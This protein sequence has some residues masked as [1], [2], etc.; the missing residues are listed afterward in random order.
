MAGSLELDTLQQDV[1][2][3]AIDTVLVCL[4]NICEMQD[5]DR[6]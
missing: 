4:P 3:G 2:S 6:T 5:L 1:A